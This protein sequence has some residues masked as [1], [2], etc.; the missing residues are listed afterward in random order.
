MPIVQHTDPHT[1]TPA[2]RR[3]LID[4]WIGVTNAGAEG[5]FPIPPADE[6]EIA[7]VADTLID[8][9]APNRARLLMAMRDATLVSWVL[10][11][12]DPDPVVAH[13]GTI[14]HLQTHLAHRG[15]GQTVALLRELRRVARDEMDLEQLRLSVRG[16]TGSEKFYGIHGWREVGRWPGAL[17]LAPDDTRDE[18]L[19]TLIL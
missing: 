11:K 10:I 7:A 16:G 1:I 2:L 19:M 14:R 15:Q 17:R 4:C 6:R 18:I 8:G 5:G 12:R 3:Q 13:W 9:L